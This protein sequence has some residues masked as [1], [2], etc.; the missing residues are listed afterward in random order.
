MRDEWKERL[1]NELLPERYLPHS[2]TVSQRAPVKVFSLE[3]ISIGYAIIHERCVSYGVCPSLRDCCVLLQGWMSVHQLDSSR[4]LFGQH[5]RS[6]CCSNQIP[7]ATCG[8]G[9]LMHI[10]ACSRRTPAPRDNLGPSAS[11]TNKLYE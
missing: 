2:R 11:V 5:S 1:T 8:P 4:D 10:T 7:M 3:S 6:P 9:H